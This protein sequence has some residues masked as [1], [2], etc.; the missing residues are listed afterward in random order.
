MKVVDY[1]LGCFIEDEM[2][3]MEEVMKMFI[4]VSE[5][6]L[7]KLFLEVMNCYN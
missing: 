4:Y 1:V 7:G 3:Y 2:V 6:F 5:D